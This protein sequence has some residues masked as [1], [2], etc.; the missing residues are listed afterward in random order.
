M[1]Y[2]MLGTE[3]EEL[4]VHIA[5]TVT[6][7]H[8]SDRD[9]VLAALL[10]AAGHSGGE[11]FEN[12]SELSAILPFVRR[13]EV[14]LSV[15]G[16]DRLTINFSSDKLNKYLSSTI[17]RY[18][19]INRGSCTCSTI[20]MD[21]YLLADRVRS[22]FVLS[23][24]KAAADA[25]GP[26]RV[27]L[28]T[29][30][31]FQSQQSQ[32]LSRL[33]NVLGLS[34]NEDDAQVV[35]FP[36]GSDAEYLPLIAA[37][38]RSHV[39]AHGEAS[40]IRVINY[41]SAAGEV[42]RY[43]F[44]NTLLNAN[45]RK[46][47]FMVIYVVLFYSGTA[48]AAGGR[49][50]SPLAPRG[51]DTHIVNSLL[52]GM[53]ADWVCVVQFKPRD[54][55]TGV[56]SVQ[57]EE[58]L[59][60]VRGD[61]SA[62]D[63]AV[64]VVHVVC[65]SKTGLVHPSFDVVE[66]L[67]KEHGERVVVVVDACQLRCDLRQLK[68]F[69]DAGYL[70][71]VTG[72]KFF[73][74]PPFAGAVIVPNS[75]VQQIEAH[76]ASTFNQGTHQ[77]C[78]VPTG[79]RSY[80]TSF[81]VPLGMPNLRAFLAVDNNWL[82]F[83]LHLRWASSLDVMA[84]YAALPRDRVER[85]T[86][87]WTQRVR[88]LVAHQSP[89]LRVLPDAEEND[90]A[91][92]DRSNAITGIVSVVVS[93][94][95]IE[96]IGDRAA[97]DGNNFLIPGFGQYVNGKKVTIPVAPAVSAPVSAPMR[98]LNFDQ[99]KEFHRLMTLEDAHV[100]DA[101]R[102]VLVQPAVPVRCML[103]Q[104]VKL[105]DNGFAVVRIALG[106]DMVLQAL[107][108]TKDE[109]DCEE[110]EAILRQD[111]AVVTKMALLAK[112]WHTRDASLSTADHVHKLAAANQTVLIPQVPFVSAVPSIDG[113]VSTVTTA[114]KVSQ[115]LKQVY[116]GAAPVPDVAIFYDLDA[117]T[118]N[119]RTLKSDFAAAFPVDMQFT[120]CFAIKA[121]PLTF[122]MQHT[123]SLD[124]GMETASIMEVMFLFGALFLFRFCESTLNDSRFIFHSFLFS[125]IIHAQLLFPLPILGEA[126]TARLCA[127]QSCVRQPLQDPLRD[128]V[129][130]PPRRHHQRRLLR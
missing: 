103:G 78:V 66:S 93:V 102:A 104:P 70:T 119:V 14:L 99:C 94:A 39:L 84:R 107:E 43:V 1:F 62:C 63:T 7:Q 6:C 25:D 41:V 129:R 50:F 45:Y 73:T 23:V 127:A 12:I 120:H 48:A 16:D 92:A 61:L 112:N 40:K 115:V 27:Q 20:T 113:S 83:G 90:V 15:G 32:L 122:L 4:L 28:A 121:A 74:G 52:D 8:L 31:I 77:V 85:F 54:T 9:D 2:G 13:T 5:K 117:L 68:R 114:A 19:M 97:S 49:H 64:A 38:V 11:S 59:R 123:A 91:A 89:F 10:A 88:E 53:E 109:E 128:R 80:L 58:I 36:S 26:E 65:G 24:L 87:L 17:P 110:I 56:V 3:E 34:S 67:K 75:V 111:D 60:S 29:K 76:I 44:S 86:R 21:N 33:R 118:A 108:H 126:S 98:L 18:G 96:K 101:H 35:L 130:P 46:V 79:L 22:Q 124:L 100:S 72:S 106:A 125:I 57:E 42:G 116:S 37:L 82:N 51:D 95:D 55:L 69:T 105:A 30:T 81:E 47:L 71:L